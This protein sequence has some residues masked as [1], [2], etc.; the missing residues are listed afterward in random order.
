MKDIMLIL[1]FA[2]CLGWCCGNRNRII[3]DLYIWYRYIIKYLVRTCMMYMSVACTSSVQQNADHLVDWQQNVE[4][5]SDKW[6][7]CKKH[8]FCIGNNILINSKLKKILCSKKIRLTFCI[9]KFEFGSKQNSKFTVATP[10][11]NTHS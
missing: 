5:I 7:F 1:G 6:R 4:S 8:H 3:T 10:C 9:H 2:Y 11:C